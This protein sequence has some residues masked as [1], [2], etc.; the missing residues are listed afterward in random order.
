MM[1]SLRAMSG[2]KFDPVEYYALLGKMVSSDGAR[3]I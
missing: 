3:V 1:T 2:P